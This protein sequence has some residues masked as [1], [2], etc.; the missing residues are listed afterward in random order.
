MTAS[1]RVSGL[2]VVGSSP[3]LRI[4][5]ERR[6]TFQ[7]GVGRRHPP[8]GGAEFSPK[9]IDKSS[10][11]HRGRR[12]KRIYFEVFSGSLFSNFRA[13]VSSQRV[14]L[15]SANLALSRPWLSLTRKLSRSFPSAGLEAEYS[16]TVSDLL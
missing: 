4:R 10:G 8:L 9:P 1:F 7:V 3:D 16:R 15:K 5:G 14:Q 12:C 11:F 6:E 13:S 2:R